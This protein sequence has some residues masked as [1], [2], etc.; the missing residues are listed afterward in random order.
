MITVLEYGV[1]LVGMRE[2]YILTNGISYQLTNCDFIHPCCLIYC[3][4]KGNRCDSTLLQY[5]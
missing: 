4:T 5:R 2:T 1:C 3:E